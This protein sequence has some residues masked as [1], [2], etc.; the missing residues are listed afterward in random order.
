M[1]SPPMYFSEPKIQHGLPFVLVNMEIW[2]L[3]CWGLEMRALS[4]KVLFP[5]PHTEL[6]NSALCSLS[7][8]TSYSSKTVWDNQIH[9]ICRQVTKR[10]SA[11]LLSHS[12]LNLGRLQ[13]EHPVLTGFRSILTESCPNRIPSLVSSMGLFSGHGTSTE[14]R[15]LYS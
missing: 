13:R 7:S 9:S 3:G 5:Q 4:W 14:F 15:L 12:C 2:H 8:S 10:D 1:W 11:A 6:P